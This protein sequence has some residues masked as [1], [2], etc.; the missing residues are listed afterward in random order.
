MPIG[1]V[2]EGGGMR[3]AYTSG[4]LEVFLNHGIEFPNVYGISAGACNALSYISGQKNRNYD[5]FYQYIGDKRYISVENLNRTGSLFGFDFI[6]GELFH[7]LLPFDYESFFNS[8]ADL[9]VGA[10]DLKTGQTV[11]F[12]KANL[13]EDFTAVKASSS[14]P[15]I[16]NTVS[17][18]GR[19]LLDGGCATPI[20]IERSIFDGNNLN[21]V[22]L[23]RD[24]TY[25]K[26]PRPEFP[27]SV[28]RVKYGEYPNFVNSMQVRAEVYNNELEVC[29]RQEAE[30]KAVIV[31]PSRPIVTGRYEK[32]PEVLK[33]IYEMG[34]SDCERKL[35]E[36][37][38]MMARA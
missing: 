25:R 29:R 26:S 8:P 2:L 35:P 37:R 12:D 31:R 23:T 22:V 4:V 24:S 5:I 3:G 10:T 7:T 32:N 6:F 13:D 11:F 14:L 21:V 28:L 33:G 1:L 30:E 18:R 34:M 17:Y 19:E 36:I 16:S 9:K 15:F 27:R 20:P 38:A